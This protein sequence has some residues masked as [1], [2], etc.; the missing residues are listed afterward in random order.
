[1]PLTFDLP[2]D[3]LELYQ[4]INPRPEILMIFGIK[5]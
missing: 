5:G 1:M 3:Q 2:F 4:G